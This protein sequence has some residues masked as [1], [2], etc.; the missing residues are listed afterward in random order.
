V[1]QALDTVQS[2][3]TKTGVGATIEIVAYPDGHAAIAGHPLSGA[4]ELLDAVSYLYERLQLEATA[5]RDAAGR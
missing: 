1:R 2:R 4:Q 3:L 5:A